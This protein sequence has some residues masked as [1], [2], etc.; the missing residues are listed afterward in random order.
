VVS[1]GVK[2]VPLTAISC[3][4][5]A[6]FCVSSV[7]VILALKPPTDWG[8]N[9]IETSQV[10]PTVRLVSELQ[11][12][13]SLVF[14]EKFTVYVGL[15]EKTKGSSPRFVTIVV[16]AELAESCLVLGNVCDDSPTFTWIK[17]LLEASAT[18]TLP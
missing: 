8:L 1:P 3:V 10:M 13:S 17:W 16:W 2:P 11:R 12:F 14:C 15:A 5:P 7:M 18:R 9:I 4:E 6:T